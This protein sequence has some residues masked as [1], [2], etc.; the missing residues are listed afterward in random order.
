M[1]RSYEAE[2]RITPREGILDPEG[3][4]IA[5]ALANLGY[6]GV[7]RVRAGRLVR[8]RLAAASADEAREQAE[9]MCRQLLANPVTEEYEIDLD[10]IS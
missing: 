3:K 2:I 10:N 4:T 8:L 5:R 7:S 9:S 6:E 1:R